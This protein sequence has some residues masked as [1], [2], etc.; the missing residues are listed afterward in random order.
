MNTWRFDIGKLVDLVES[1]HSFRSAYVFL[2]KDEKVYSEGDVVYFYSEKGDYRFAFKTSII[3]I[4]QDIKMFEVGEWVCTKYLT[5][6][7]LFRN[8]EKFFLMQV[9]L[10]D[11]TLNASFV[12]A[13]RENKPVGPLFEPGKNGLASAELSFL[14]L[15]DRQV[16][17]NDLI[18][19]YNE[20]GSVGLFLLERC[21]DK[22]FCDALHRRA[23][24]ILSTDHYGL[25]RED[26]IILKSSAAMIAINFYQGRFWDEIEERYQGLIH[27]DSDNGKLVFLRDDW[28]EDLRKEV[29]KKDP[30][31]VPGS[32]YISVP[33]QMAIVQNYFCQQFFSLVF[34]AIY[35]NRLSVTYE[36]DDQDMIEDAVDSFLDSLIGEEDRE[37]VA[38]GN[39]LLYYGNNQQRFSVSK[40]TIHVLERGLYRTDVK[41]LIVS[42]IQKM[43]DYR[44]YGGTRT[45]ALCPILE[46]N[47]QKW[48]TDSSQSREGYDPDYARKEERDPERVAYIKKPR[49]FYREGK[50]YARI[51]SN[52]FPEEI[53]KDSIKIRIFDSKKQLIGSLED[54]GL[55][56]FDLIGGKKGKRTYRVNCKKD[57]CLPDCLGGYSYQYHEAD[58]IHTESRKYLF[59]NEKGWEILPFHDY[60]GFCL[61]ITKVP[62]VGVKKESEF[63][64]KASQTY[65]TTFQI[66]R[67]TAFTVERD[68][69][70]FNSSA[71]LGIGCSPYP[72][73]KGRSPHEN[74]YKVYSDV[75]SL[76]FESEKSAIELD[77]HVDDDVYPLRNLSVAENEIG[78]AGIHRFFLEMPKKLSPGFHKMWV[79]DKNGFLVQSVGLEDRL[80]GVDPLLRIET[81]PNSSTLFV[82]G[83]L[84]AAQTIQFDVADDECVIPT[85]DEGLS[86]VFQNPLLRY[87]FDKQTPK[88]LSG[89]I[90]NA[91]GIKGADFLYIITPLKNL[92][93][94]LSDPI[95]EKEMAV[96]LVDENSTHHKIY[97][98]EIAPFI[99]SNP[100]VDLI[101]ES[102]GRRLGALRFYAVPFVREENLDLDLE[103][104][105]DPEKPGEGKITVRGSFEGRGKLILAISKGDSS[106]SAQEL[107]LETRDNV[108][109]ISVKGITANKEWKIQLIGELPEDPFSLME[110]RRAVVWEKRIFWSSFES[111]EVGNLYPIA[112]VDWDNGKEGKKDPYIY[113]DLTSK[114]RVRATLQILTKPTKRSCQAIFYDSQ[115]K[116]LQHL[117]KVRV[118]LMKDEHQGIC[119]LKISRLD[120]GP[121]FAANSG[122]LDTLTSVTN[123]CV[124]ALVL[125]TKGSSLKE[126][127]WRRYH[128]E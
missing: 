107:N 43:I 61:A 58:P 36:I 1:F 5:D 83:A 68:W 20:R 71:R 82:E 105:I 110:A 65:R 98:P 66:D 78:K 45:Q 115:F 7:S 118:D 114:Q 19:T 31:Y 26:T 67:T 109:G 12:K 48:L 119:I 9:Q 2:P 47:F 87:S 100:I 74:D 120:G 11:A 84:I 42:L 116:P 122:I 112:K 33:I 121:V 70:Y 128:V 64:D 76:S 3:S 25:T 104:G 14:R 80:L 99:Q 108:F 62:M 72:D 44:Y 27:E 55:E 93:V 15:A 10:L 6:K 63:F 94:R 102:G 32:D 16:T 54:E 101:V 38:Q 24:H 97:L 52:E 41:E 111:L 96:S 60:E 103:M 124:T 56:I 89:S 51:P 69:I 81:N 53:A 92:S 125:V 91:D 28:K 21:R 73:V 113:M 17:I 35:K 123:K 90:E 126:W 29:F 95:N 117:G 85:N 57:I 34:K 23:I 86:L 40:Y 106:D 39:L 30:A 59:F 88:K 8:P 77:L 49:L 79:S 46:E 18:K 75:S 4:R 22:D 127:D 50:V 13:I 37:E